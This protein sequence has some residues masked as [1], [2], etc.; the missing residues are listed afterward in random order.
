MLMVALAVGV[1]ESV[2]ARLRMSMLPVFLGGTVALSL[3]A[4]VIAFRS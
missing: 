2:V 3:L 4:L 1:I